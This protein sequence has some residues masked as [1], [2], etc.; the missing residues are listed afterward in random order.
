MV[1][2]CAIFSFCQNRKQIYRGIKVLWE[3]LN[4]FSFELPS[5]QFD[6][7]AMYFTWGTVDIDKRILL[8]CNRLA[9]LVG[10]RGRDR[11]LPDDLD[12]RAVLVLPNLLR[13]VDAAP[14]EG[15]EAGGA[16]GLGG[17]GGAG[18]GGPQVALLRGGAGAEEGEAVGIL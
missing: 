8:E 12:P 16:V 18:V 14:P 9:R 17:G 5:D 2:I 4:N 1:H 10:R 3:I 6:L 15:G 13:D 7:F 11:R